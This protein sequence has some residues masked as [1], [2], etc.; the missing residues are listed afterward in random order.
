MLA[1]EVKNR[2]NEKTPFYPKGNQ[3]QTKKSKNKT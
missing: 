1:I 3:K 2:R